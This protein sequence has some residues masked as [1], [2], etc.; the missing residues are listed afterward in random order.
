MLSLSSVQ[1]SQAKAVD[2]LAADISAQLNVGG[3]G[4]IA[5]ALQV[6]AVK[7]MHHAYR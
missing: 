1:S 4:G 5:Q 3:G 6:G 7:P 2:K